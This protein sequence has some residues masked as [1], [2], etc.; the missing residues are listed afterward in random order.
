M[1]NFQTVRQA[2]NIAKKFI[3]INTYKWLEAAAEDGYTKEK[4]VLDL[5]NIKIKPKFLNKVGNLNLEINFFGK[6]FNSP[7]VIAPMGHQ[8]QF[9]KYGEIE[10]AKGARNANILSFYG[11]Q[12]RM[13][14]SDIKNN[15]KSLSFGWEIF[16]FGDLNWIDNQINDAH[17][18]NCNSIVLCLDANVRSHR[19]LDRETSYDARKYGKRTNPLPQNVNQAKFYDWQLVR[20]IIKKT[21]LPVIVKGILTLE[22]AKLAIKHGAKGIWISNHGGRMLNS[23]I[24]SIEALK[25][26]S[27]IKKKNK[28]IKIIA[29]GGIEKGSDIIKYL[30]S[31]AD[32]VGIGRAALYGLIING[33]KG[34]EK[35]IDI[36][37]SELRVAMINGGFRS[38]KDF[39]KNRI[40][41]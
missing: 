2:S 1:K 7:V 9:H 38:F 10:T 29:D 23:G 11:T 39:T 31:G 13:S 3:R 30:C 40:Y 19:Y 41:E 25:K 5:K 6:I 12:G 8:T 26:I 36:L 17:K 27:V 35:I 34:V 21:K 14:I 22:D 32:I 28:K 4:N 16:P 18:C 24:S 20:H 33:S 15:N 37:N